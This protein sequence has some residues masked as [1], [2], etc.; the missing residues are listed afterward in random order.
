MA[1]VKAPTIDEIIAD[2]R[3]TLKVYNGSMVKFYARMVDELES[4]KG[5]RIE[6]SNLKHT[7]K[8]FTKYIRDK[9]M[10][11]AWS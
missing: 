11:R 1:R 9:Y 3:M 6:R 4:G 10:E 7:V 5:T 2:A 8:W